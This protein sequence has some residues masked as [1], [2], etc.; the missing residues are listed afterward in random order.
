[1]TYC[2]QVFGIIDSANASGSKPQLIFVS[3]YKS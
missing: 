3:D 2:S 1:M